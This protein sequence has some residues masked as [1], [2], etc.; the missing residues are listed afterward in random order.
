M[1]GH[2]L[3][4]ENGHCHPG[5]FTKNASKLLEEIEGGLP[6]KCRGQS[7]EGI[8]HRAVSFQRG[9]FHE[10]VWH[11]SCHIVAQV[12][13]LLF[14]HAG[15]TEESIQGIRNIGGVNQLKPW[16]HS[17]VISGREKNLGSLGDLILTRN[18]HPDKGTMYI[19]QTL[20]NLLC[21]WP[22][23]RTLVI[24]HNAMPQPQSTDDTKDFHSFHDPKE[25]TPKGTAWHRLAPGWNAAGPWINAVT[26]HDGWPILFRVDVAM[27]RAW[28]QENAIAE[29]QVLVFRRNEKTKEYDAFVLY[30]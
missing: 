2:F 3:P 22:G 1:I 19:R 16:F 9:L 24:G 27:S 4:L 5:Y 17:M 12:G 18:Q 21:S 8:C 15:L 13:S 28:R 26:G 29:P 30:K 11:N 10:A 6:Q 14:I 20:P 25:V 7:N 23:V